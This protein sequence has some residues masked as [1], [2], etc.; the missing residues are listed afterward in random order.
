[1]SYTEDTSCC[2]VKE[3]VDIC[4][5]KLNNES[6]LRDITDLRYE[7]GDKGNCCY[8]FFTD[9]NLCEYGNSLKKYITDN[10]LGT[11]TRSG[12]KK[13]PNSGNSIKVY[14]WTVNNGALYLW[15]KK[16][17]GDKWTEVY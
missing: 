7:D 2:G 17:G 16:H 11:V 8:Y 10:K 4:D 13:N 1:M 3:I 6:L 5:E 12:A 9:I 14:L 15:H